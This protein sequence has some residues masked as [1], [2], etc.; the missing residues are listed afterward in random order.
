MDICCFDKTGTLTSNNLVIE[1]VAGLNSEKNS[2]IISA[3]DAPVDTIKVLATCNSLVQ[4]EDGLV[5]DPLEKAT[6]SAIDWTLTKGDA[7]V[8]KKGK[9]PGMKIFLR[10][11][12]SSNLKRMSVIAGFNV[13]GTGET[14]Y[15]VSI[16]GA[17]EILKPMVYIGFKIIVFKFFINYNL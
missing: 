17:P 7:V 5:G 9:I 13:Q 2:E 1:G 15:F 10:N 14:N 16:K 6:L 8:P 12:F 11:H 4:L 3:Q